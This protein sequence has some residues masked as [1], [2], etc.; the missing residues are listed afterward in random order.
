MTEKRNI[1]EL[2][3]KESNNLHNILD[4][5]DVK[6]FKAL[7][8]ELRDTW[9][10]KQVFRTETEMRFSVLNDMKYPTPAAKYWQC[11][12]E[13]NV[14]LENLMSLSFDYRRNEIKIKKLEEKLLIEED[15]LKKELFQIDIDEKN[16][17]KASMQLTARDRMREIKLW[18]KL[19][20]EV[21]D[22]TFDKED[23]NTHQLE[24]YHK[25]MINRKDTLT[26]GSSQPEVFNVLGQLQTIERVKK[27][28]GQLE[29]T[30]RE[31]LSQESKLGAKPE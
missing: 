24:S 14:Y 26:A 8:E 2:V 10:K 30:K 5:N 11:V 6:D 1:Q 27:E 25:I 15:S 17:T 7:T 31:A 3:E 19:K 23:V 9:T 18:S 29:N 20:K 4:P 21:D 16:F 22:G 28:R 12:R 13:Q